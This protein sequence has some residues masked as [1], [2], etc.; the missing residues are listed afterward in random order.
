MSIKFLTTTAIALGMIDAA[1]GLRAQ[2]SAGF[3]SSSYRPQRIRVGALTPAGADRLARTIPGS[4]ILI[5]NCGHIPQLEQSAEFNRL[6]R[7]F[8]TTGGVTSTQQ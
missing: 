2:P 7:E 6:V 5:D 1:V 4:T 3:A 8:L